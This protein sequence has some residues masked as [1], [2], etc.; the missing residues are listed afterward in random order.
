MQI[1]NHWPSVNT[2]K[3][4]SIWDSVGIYMMIPDNLMVLPYLVIFSLSPACIYTNININIYFKIPT[5]FQKIVQRN[6]SA[7]LSLTDP[8]YLYYDMAVK[9]QMSSSFVIPV[10]KLLA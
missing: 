6:K 4:F 9:F 2:F 8:F 7:L 5:Y 10:N 1:T 3:I